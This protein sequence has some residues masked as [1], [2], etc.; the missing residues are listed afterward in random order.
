MV[1]FKDM[2]ISAI[3]ENK[4][5]LMVKLF[6]SENLNIKKNNFYLVKKK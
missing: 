6:L 4:V 1:F 2:V 3:S 5:V